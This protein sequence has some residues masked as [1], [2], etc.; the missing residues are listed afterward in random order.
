[1][2]GDALIMYRPDFDV[3]RL[4]GRDRRLFYEWSQLER[5]FG[6]GGKIRFEVAECNSRGLPIKYRVAYHIRSIQGVE[7]VEALDMP[8][9]SNPPIFASLFLMTITLPDNYPCVDAPVEFRFLTCDEAGKAIPDTYASLLWGVRRVALYL[10]YDLYH[11]AQHPPY[12]EDPKV[13]RWVVRQGEPNGWVY[14]DQ[15]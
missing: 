13:A 3:N 4:S 6:Q 8:G 14:F 1:M 15:N 7:R 12:P 10:R 11:A 5:A 9:V 2:G